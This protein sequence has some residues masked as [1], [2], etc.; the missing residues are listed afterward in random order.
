MR[1]I[2][3]TPIAFD[4]LNEW[5][6]SDFTTYLRINRL[7]KEVNRTPFHGIGKPEPLKNELKGYWSRRINQEDRLVYKVSNEILTIISCKNHY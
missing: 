3:F 1:N 2:M 4:Q 5:A 7:I 6:E